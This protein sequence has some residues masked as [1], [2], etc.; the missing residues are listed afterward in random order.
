MTFFRSDGVTEFAYKVDREIYHSELCLNHSWFS[1]LHDLFQFGSIYVKWSG[2]M[3]VNVCGDYVLK[4]EN[5][6]GTRMRCDVE[7]VKK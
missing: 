2:F 7:E 1:S 5:G 6:D 4:F 3:I